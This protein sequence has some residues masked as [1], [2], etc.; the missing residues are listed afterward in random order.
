MEGL[1]ACHARM[2]AAPREC[3]SWVVQQEQVRQ[4]RQQLELGAQV[5]RQ[6]TLIAKSVQRA[7][8]THRRLPETTLRPRMSSWTTRGLASTR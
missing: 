1:H 5:A 8:E 4:L 2:S 6:H 3:S 7:R